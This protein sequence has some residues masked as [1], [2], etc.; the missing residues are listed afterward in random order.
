V[1]LTLLAAPGVTVTLVNT[2]ASL[3]P[4]SWRMPDLACGADTWA[5]V[6]LRV[7]ATV[8]E[9]PQALFTAAISYTDMQGTTVQLAP[10][11]LPLP[12]V[13]DAVYGALAPDTTVA[14][15]IEELDLAGV[16]LQAREAAMRG[17]WDRATQ[18][19]NAVEAKVAGNP[20]LSGVHN[21]LR[22]LVAE[23]DREGYGKEALDSAVG[24]SSRRFRGA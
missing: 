10:V 16:S 14:Q 1:R 6:R 3:G 5:L 24:M 13:A 15:R 11:T 7:P 4:D 12:R 22:M 9:E 17:D 20:W 19:L 21:E 18:L 8:S 2:L 23:R